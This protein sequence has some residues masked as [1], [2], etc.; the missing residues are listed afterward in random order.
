[1]LLQS[2]RTSLPSA[3]ATTTSTTTTTTSTTTTS[4]IMS[5]TTNGNVS[6]SRGRHAAGR[7]STVVDA[8]RMSI[9]LQEQQDSTFDV[10]GGA[11]GRADYYGPDGGTDI[12]SSSAR[13]SYS[14]PLDRKAKSNNSNQNNSHSYSNFNYHSERSLSP[15]VSPVRNRA[16]LRRQRGNRRSKLMGPAGSSVLD[17]NLLEEEPAPSAFSYSPAAY[18]SAPS[19]SMPSPSPSPSKTQLILQEEEAYRRSSRSISTSSIPTVEE[20]PEEEPSTSHTEDDAAFDMTQLDM[21]AQRRMFEDFERQNSNSSRSSNGS[22]SCWN[23]NNNN[24]NNNTGYDYGN[25]Y[26]ISSNNVSGYA[27]NTDNLS[28]SYRSANSSSQRS[29]GYSRRSQ[30]RAER[31]AAQ[32]ERRRSY[33]Y[34]NTTPAPGPEPV[35]VPEPAPAPVEPQPQSQELVEIT[36]GVQLPLRTSAKTWQAILEGRI[37]VTK[38]FCCNNDLTCSDADAFVL[39]ADCW[40]FNPIRPGADVDL[41]SPYTTVAIGVKNEDLTSWLSE[42][43]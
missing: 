29:L 10:D 42:R 35:Y 6:S 25:N 23:S 16:G 5:A 26:N 19:L 38:C 20:G 41:S 2:Q 9:L 24:N 15:K 14:P 28:S 27:N 39:C 7:M 12:L 30:R 4:S 3:T 34:S 11:A 40:V 18:S 33:G 31:Q 21:E 13:R 32:Q 37:S 36:P 43:R 22:N 17:F 1:M 8:G